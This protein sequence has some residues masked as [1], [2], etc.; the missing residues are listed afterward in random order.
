MWGPA[1][2]WIL[3]ANALLGISQ[4]VTWS[5]TVIMTI[6]FVGPTRRGLASFWRGLGFAIGGLLAGLT[7][8]AVGC[9]VRCGWSRVSL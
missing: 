2:N 9:Q 3:A 8:D 5:T 1:W 7:A 4:G 6:N